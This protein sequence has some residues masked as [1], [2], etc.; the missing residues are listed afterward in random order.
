MKKIIFIIYSLILV[1]LNFA[2]K[3]AVEGNI[4]F[5]AKDNV[6][7]NF[8]S[9][10]GIEVSDTLFG[11]NKNPLLLVKYKSS[12]SVAAIKLPGAAVKKGD[13]V[14]A[15]AEL[16]SR[17]GKKEEK[18]DLSKYDKSSGKNVKGISSRERYS[19]KIGITSYSNFSNTNN[20]I[21]YQRWRYALSLGAWNMFNSDFSFTTYATMNYRA[22]QWS[23]IKS[24]FSQALRVYDFAIN[25]KPSEILSFWVGRRINQKVANISVIDGGSAEIS[26]G[27]INVGL[28]AGSRP[29]PG[30]FGVNFN[31]LEYG[32]Y[33]S[34]DDSLANG[35]MTNT[36][37]LMQQLN[38]QKVDRR[39]LYFQHSDNIFNNMNIFFSTE[40]DLYKNINGI[41]ENIFRLTGFYLS[42]RY[43]FSHSVSASISYDERK[44]VIYYETYKSYAEK[45]FD[46]AVRRGARIRV[47]FRPFKYVSASVNAGFRNRDGDKQ[48]NV[49]LGGSVSHSK[50]PFFNLS[51]S[52][53]G[54]FINTS[55]LTGGSVGLRFMRSFF[56]GFM[57]S[58]LSMKGLFY[59]YGVGELLINQNVLG[60][61]VS[62]NLMK[63]LSLTITHESVF[64]GRDTF[65]RTFISLNQRF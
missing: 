31:Y 65:G 23:D 27:G 56:N 2:Q 19:G 21:D 57:N 40:L 38:H 42:L 58:S 5:V 26:L 3:I 52:L 55:Y 11:K 51:G 7:V 62:F 64:E 39:F 25:Y 16:K 35:K 33:F 37:A 6:Y 43:R 54:N 20:I 61:D 17:E 46:E 22:D 1:N 29:N 47:N 41:E 12:T 15:Y 60:F 59:A 13:V 49:N 63:K 50:L 48:P 14:I 8:E 32:A 45:L 10:E 53:S 18:F 24:N 44:N 36:L 34:R 9:T 30:D 4:S 28:L